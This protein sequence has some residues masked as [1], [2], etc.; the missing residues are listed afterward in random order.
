MQEQRHPRTNGNVARMNRYLPFSVS[1]EQIYEEYQTDEDSLSL[2]TEALKYIL[3][4][5]HAGAR[6]IVLTGD[7]GHGKTHLC[8]K[9]LS[10]Y[11]GYGVAESRKLLLTQC[12]G[13]SIIPPLS[14][15]PKPL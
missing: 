5:L 12:D 13:R 3:S 2:D 6:C 8:R 7:A 11:L 4:A 15:V 1:H 9:L 14:P 10:N